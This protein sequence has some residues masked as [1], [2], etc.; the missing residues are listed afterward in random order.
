MNNGSTPTSRDSSPEIALLDAVERI[1]ATQSPLTLRMRDIA[2]EANCSLG[3]AYNYFASKDDLIGA[4]LDRLAQ[5]MAASG[6]STDN[7]HD[8]M[9]ALLDTMHANPAFPRLVTTLLL[10]GKDVSKVMSGHPLVQQ[11]AASARD[12]GAADPIGTAAMMALLAIGTN[13]YSG[14]INRATGREPDDTRLRESA[15]NMYA[16]WFPGPTP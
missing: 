13:T 11:I 10:E 1:C 14:M 3:L 5:R 4:T 6:T 12:S 9:N 15:A 16:N 8:A 7:A 2:T